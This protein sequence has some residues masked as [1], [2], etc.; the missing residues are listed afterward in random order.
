MQTVGWT[1]GVI[2]S[3]AL[4]PIVSLLAHLLR[5]GEPEWAPVRVPARRVTSSGFRRG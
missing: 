2:G 1:L 4:G 5:A 3:F